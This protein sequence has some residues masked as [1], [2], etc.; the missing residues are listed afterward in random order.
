MVGSRA[1]SL[2]PRIG[3]S[4]V[5]LREA[6]LFRP[7]AKR[8]KL[9]GGIPFCAGGGFFGVVC[10]KRPIG[11]ISFLVEHGGPGSKKTL[12]GATRARRIEG[13]SRQCVAGRGIGRQR[14]T[15]PPISCTVLCR[16]AAFLEEMHV[17][18]LGRHV[19]S[20]T[21][22]PF[23]ECARQVPSH[24]PVHFLAAPRPDEDLDGRITQLANRDDGGR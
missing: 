9:A 1:I 5:A 23:L 2:G 19:A 13:Y 6:V 16:A 24:V 17:M 20:R 4:P 22:Q 11:Y 10:S 14:A 21:L 8:S 12:C 3:P 18:L 15:D 7:G